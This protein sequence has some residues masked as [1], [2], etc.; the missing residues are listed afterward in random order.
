M[1]LHNPLE[2]LQAGR[3]ASNHSDEVALN[4]GA[5][6]ICGLCLCLKGDTKRG[7]SE[8]A[9]ARRLS[10]QDRV[11]SLARLKAIGYWGV[12]KVQELFEA[13]FFAGLR[14]AGMPEE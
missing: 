12:P 4:R 1:F 5:V 11:S 6:A 3:R 2:F 13:T 9:E 10:L 7:A 14:K 8:L